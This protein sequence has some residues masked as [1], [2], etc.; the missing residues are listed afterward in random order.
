MISK[1]LSKCATHLVYIKVALNFTEG[2]TVAWSPGI[3]QKCILK[4]FCKISCLI[5]QYVH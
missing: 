3:L 2:F 5:L 1:C 4:L